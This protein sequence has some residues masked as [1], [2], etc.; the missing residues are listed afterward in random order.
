MAPELVEMMPTCGRLFLEPFAGRGNVFFAAALSLDF[1]RWQLNDFATYPF[2]EAL[3]RTG[4]RIRVPVRT[5]EE[6]FKQKK[7]FQRGS[8]RAILLEPYL[9]FSGG[10]YKSGGF[11]GE[12]S[13][14]QKGYTQTLLDCAEIL[15]KTKAKITKSHWKRLAWHRLGTD[16]FA[17]FDPPYFGA[18]VRAYSNKFDHVAMV[19]LLR[20]AKFKWMLTEYKQ[21]FYLESLGKPCR[22]REVQLACDGDGKRRRV[23]CVWKNY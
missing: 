18:D 16:D 1:E 11:G 20:G 2:F 12:R 3:K 21:G 8:D 10:G 4:G 19:K 17:F 13:A 14:G 5:K 7:A 9:T 22:E 15:K 23:E 6:F